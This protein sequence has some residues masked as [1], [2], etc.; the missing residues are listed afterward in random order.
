VSAM[1]GVEGAAKQCEIHSD[2]SYSFRVLPVGCK[3]RSK[4]SM[5]CRT[6]YQFSTRR[7]SWKTVYC[8]SA[9]IVRNGVLAFAG[10]FT[11]TRCRQISS[12]RE[13]PRCAVLS[14]ASRFST[15]IQAGLVSADRKLTPW[16]DKPDTN[17]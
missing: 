16:E 15:D 11:G 3:S 1:D 4:C 13:N 6:P 17:R 14:F 12:V 9:G 5:F 10:P 8:G 7:L 2:D